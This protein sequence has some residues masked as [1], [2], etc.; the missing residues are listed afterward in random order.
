[1]AEAD[2]Q[3]LLII[4]GGVNGAGVAR[5]AAGRGLRVALLEAGDIGGAT[6]SAS[7]KLVHGGLR[8]LE[9]REF[10]L[11]RKALAEREVILRNA[12]HISRPM[13]FLLPL[14]PHLRPRWM[15]GWGCSS[16]IIWPAAG[17]CRAA[18]RWSCRRM[19]PGRPLPGTCAGPARRQGSRF[20]P[21]CRD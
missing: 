3:D 18:G 13:P 6:S 5:D 1:M 10:A 16:M 7:S 21:P 4:G 14:E 2:I 15:I 9:F 8:Y 19:P 17:K 12:P 20:L 11:V